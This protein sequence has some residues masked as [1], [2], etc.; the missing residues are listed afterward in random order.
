MRRNPHYYYLLA[1]A[2][3]AALALPLPAQDEQEAVHTDLGLKMQ[4]AA[5][6]GDAA[7]LF[8]R[9]WL[10]A[11]EGDKKQ[12]E[13]YLRRAAEQDYPQAGLLYGLWCFAEHLYRPAL[14]YL[15]QAAAQEQPDAL[16]CL[17]YMHYK[18]WGVPRAPEEA[19]KFFEQAA[20]KGHTHAGA[21][22]ALMYLEGE[23]TPPDA[24]Q[25]ARLLVAIHSAA[26]SSSSEESEESEDSDEDADTSD[27]MPETI[28]SLSELRI[29]SAEHLLGLMQLRGVGLPEEP[30]TAFPL[31]VQDADTAE[32]D[33]ATQLL[34]ATLYRSGLGID[35][36]A[37]RAEEWELRLSA[38]SR[39]QLAPLVQAYL[40]ADTPE[41][42]REAL[43]A[44]LN[45]PGEGIQS[46]EH[47]QLIEAAMQPPPYALH[48]A[49]R[50]EYRMQL[51]AGEYREENGTR[52]LRIGGDGAF[53]DRLFILPPEG[54]L[55]ILSEDWENGT[56]STLRYDAQKGQLQ[57]LFTI[58]KEQLHE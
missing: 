25:A 4:Q 44:L 18:G 50:T 55:Y 53:G 2:S 35:E 40:S 19:F 15:S 9:G 56:Y 54:E 57:P 8:A 42:K 58:S 3:A 1:A 30:A 28:L 13:E 12:A 11:Q 38:E 16:F 7:A 51:E 10:Y 26:E 31:L 34:I 24:E 22:L 48:E 46:P 36:N 27:N 21:M 23:A 20:I 14:L 39:E 52:Y 17:G 6:Q 45:P 47:Q 41:A 5:E 37:A 33:E 32:C 49:S 29:P 43:V